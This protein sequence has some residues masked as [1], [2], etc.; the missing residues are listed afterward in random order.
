MEFQQTAVNFFTFM[1]IYVSFTFKAQS[2]GYIFSIF[3]TSSSQGLQSMMIV[4]IICF[5]FSG[6]I[7]NP[8]NVGTW[9]SWIRYFNPM[10]WAIQA[11]IINEFKGQTTV[12]VNM[13]DQFH[14]PNF[15]IWHCVVFFIGVGTLLRFLSF[16][17]MYLVASKR[18]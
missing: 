3:V 15:E 17:G 14:E 10:F 7:A 5:L 2:F 8:T 12:G 1:G 4:A 16:F 18:M 9:L 6:M 11:A 13:Y